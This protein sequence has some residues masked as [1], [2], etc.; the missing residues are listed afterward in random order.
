MGSLA[1]TDED[2][3]A[4]IAKKKRKSSACLTSRSIKD[5]FARTSHREG[6][7]EEYETLLEGI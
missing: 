3:S 6:A 4:E 5:F 2:Q 7:E 1:R